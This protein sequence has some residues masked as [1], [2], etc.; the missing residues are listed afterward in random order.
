LDIAYREALTQGLANAQY[1]LAP[2][3]TLPPE[4]STS[5]AMI[6]N[7]PQY[8]LTTGDGNLLTLLVVVLFIIVLVLI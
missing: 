1:P 6:N 8:V 4:N 5:F 3:I 7:L 2:M